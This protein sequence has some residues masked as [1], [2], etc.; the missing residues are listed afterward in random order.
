MKYELHPA[1][2]AWPTMKPQELRKLA[3]EIAERLAQHGPANS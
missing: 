1:C 3:D 2:S